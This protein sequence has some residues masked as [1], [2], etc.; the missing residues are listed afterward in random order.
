MK[1]VP[2]WVMWGIPKNAYHHQQYEC[3]TSPESWDDPSTSPQSAQ[4]IGRIKVQLNQH[5]SE[6]WLQVVQFY[7][8]K[9]G[10]GGSSSYI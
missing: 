10:G 1:D 3:K 9:K 2:S 5:K 6:A 7:I 8:E 4:W